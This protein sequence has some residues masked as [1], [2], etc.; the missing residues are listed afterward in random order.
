MS[1]IEIDDVSEVNRTPPQVSP[2]S[3][4][5][6]PN[7]NEFTRKKAC[8]QLNFGPVSSVSPKRK[9]VKFVSSPLKH[10]SNSIQKSNKRKQK[11]KPIAVSQPEHLK[12][13]IIETVKGLYEFKLS[14]GIPVKTVV[15]TV[16]ESEGQKLTS[17]KVFEI[18]QAAIGKNIIKKQIKIGKHSS[19]SSGKDKRLFCNMILNISARCSDSDVSNIIFSESEINCDQD[20]EKTEV[21]AESKAR[22]KALEN[23]KMILL[24]RLSASTRSDNSDLSELSELKEELKTFEQLGQTL[25]FLDSEDLTYTN[26]L[27]S[28]LTFDTVASQVQESCPKLTRLV[29][30]IA[31][32]DRSHDN[33]RRDSSC[34]FK[35]A[36]QMLFALVNIRSQKSKNSFSK[37][38]G[39]ML[40]AHGAEE[41]LLNLLESFGLCKG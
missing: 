15:K 24:E 8:R 34:K 26:R 6:Q 20:L 1:D 35:N 33:L 10:I 38:F 22:I 5:D 16:N 17:P 9:Q 23:E 32:G 41:A 19:N 13:D 11:N 12:Q 21:K 27:P 4:S 25:D 36:V 7:I 30:V 18:L 14:S 2:A 29:N 39:I 37:L 40:I 31:V 3:E 28:S